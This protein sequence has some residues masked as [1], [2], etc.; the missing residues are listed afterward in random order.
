MAAPLPHLFE[1]TITQ[2][3]TLVPELRHVTPDSILV[4]VDRLPPR[5][6][7]QTVG[8]RNARGGRAYEAVFPR[9][10]FGGRDIRYLMAFHPRICVADS[11]FPCDPIATV[12]HELWHIAPTCDGTIRRARH[13]RRF[14]AI[15]Q[16]LSERYRTA[17]GEELPTMSRE[18]SV[19]LRRWR[20]DDEP[21]IAYVRR[22]PFV[23]SAAALR[24]IRWQA[25][26]G[27]D[28]LL[29]EERPLTSLVPHLYRYMCPRGHEMTCHVHFRKPR[30]CAKC[31][32]TFNPRFL[33]R[34]IEP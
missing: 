22:S 21:S 33:Y 6:Q 10:T 20:T 3:C 7:G 2:A 31:S 23:H 19:L 32:E 25:N 11:G 13:G 29:V 17:G 27:E 30:S 28:D 12:I 16:R 9:V 8:L 1:R 5:R 24:H 14:N 34:L 26:W 4:L 15:V 18:Q